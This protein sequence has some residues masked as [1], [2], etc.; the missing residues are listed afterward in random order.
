MTRKVGKS[1]VL[2][3]GYQGAKKITADE[4]YEMIEAS[5]NNARANSTAMCRAGRGAAILS[6]VDLEALAEKINER[7]AK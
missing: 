2:G 6:P 1:S 4:L 3:R 7:M 5:P